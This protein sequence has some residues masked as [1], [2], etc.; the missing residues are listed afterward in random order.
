MRYK[1]LFSVFVYFFILL[2]L[3]LGIWQLYRLNW[4][5]NLINEIDKSLSSQPIVFD[6]KFPSNFKK[7]SFKGIIDNDKIIFLY[8]LNE[9]G[10][11]GFDILNPVKIDNYNFLLN[12]GWIP[13]NLKDQN[14]ENNKKNFSGI[15]KKK[16]KN[17]LFKPENNINEN[18]WFKLEDE[19]LLKYTGINFSKYL[20]FQTGQDLKIIKPKKITTNIPNNHLKYALTWF[21]LAVSIFLVYL[22]FR[23][24]N[25]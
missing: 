5:L 1:I 7:V 24:K 6:G 15:L 9:K 20:I 14:F 23:K 19:D 22:Y 8:S 13:R 3:F 18:Y 21:S 4:K 16:A 25:F 17:N 11:P 2:F 10:Q 12:R